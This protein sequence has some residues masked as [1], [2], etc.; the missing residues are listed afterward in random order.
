MH[1]ETKGISTCC[2]STIPTTHAHTHCLRFA[3]LGPK[4]ILLP[5]SSTWAVPYRDPLPGCM[6]CCFFK[7]MY[8]LL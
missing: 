4:F 8:I 6:T 1:I 7:K 2:I 5:G 3:V